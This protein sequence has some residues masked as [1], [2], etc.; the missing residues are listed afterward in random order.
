MSPL[1]A[2]TSSTSR[3][4]REGVAIT[5]ID[6]REQRHLRHIERL[7]SQPIEVAPLPTE[8]AP[9][10]KRLNAMRAALEE[11][12]KAGGLDGPR[13]FVASLAHDV[14]V[15]DIAAAAVSLL[16]SDGESAEDDEEERDERVARPSERDGR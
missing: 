12:I 4:G 11:R 5:L 15:L 6:P 8:A 1:G 13:A 2:S 9:Q 3:I 14:D 16:Q 10:A 7:T